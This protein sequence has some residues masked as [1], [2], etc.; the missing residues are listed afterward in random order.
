M[1]AYNLSTSYT[2][3]YELAD[4]IENVTWERH[5]DP[6]PIKTTGYKGRWGDFDTP[7]LQSMAAGLALSS[8]AAAVVVWQP[9]SIDTPFTPASGHILRRESKA[10]E[11]WVVIAVLESPLGHWMLAC[12]KEVTN[13]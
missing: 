3:D 12:D 9:N 1:T 5:G 10:N 11:G 8:E 13:G 4:W 6:D 7:D 2:N